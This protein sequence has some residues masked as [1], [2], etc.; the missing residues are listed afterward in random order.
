MK[1]RFFVNTNRKMKLCCI[2]TFVC[3]LFFFTGLSA[4]CAN[5]QGFKIEYMPNL[6]VEK[7][8]KNFVQN[9]DIK[10]SLT[11][12]NGTSILSKQQVDLILNKKQENLTVNKN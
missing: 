11:D 3:M 6:L 2:F 5:K 9:N 12:E 10:L 1:I 4:F 7:N 8:N